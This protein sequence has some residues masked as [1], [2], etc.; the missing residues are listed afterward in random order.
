M[1]NSFFQFKQ[2]NIHQQF[3]AMKV[4]TD[5]CL[6]GAWVGKKAACQFASS[7]RI[8]DVGAGTGL[9][10][11]ML[12]QQCEATIDG[13][14]LD[15]ATA[16]EA[17]SNCNASVWSKRLHIIEGDV[18][19]FEPIETYDLIISNPP[20][21]ERSL[22]SYRRL[23]NIA[24]HDAGLDFEQLVDFTKF[25][26]KEDGSFA[27]LVPFFRETEMIKLCSA[28]KL[29]LQQR[30]R[31]QHTADKPIIRSMLW[32]QQKGANRIHDD[33]ISINGEDGFYSDAFVN[34][35]Q[36]YYLFL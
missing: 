36:P 6:F 26:L 11:L 35:L 19:H 5:S 16:T 28:K 3:A 21:Y 22:Q 20:F 25:A 34:L 4:S 7:A 17:T 15:V 10:M 33:V 14:E 32:F 30:M 2:F 29:V 18:R 24:H 12:A 9:L 31:V 8:L 13:I 23:N 27:V 1:P